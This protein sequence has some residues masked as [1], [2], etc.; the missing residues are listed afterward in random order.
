MAM[1]GMAYWFLGRRITGF[2]L[3]VA[4]LCG[5]FA[6]L[7]GGLPGHWKLLFGLWG[8]V[9]LWCG[10]EV[11]WLLQKQE[12]RLPLSLKRAVLAFAGLW[13]GPLCLGCWVFNRFWGSSYIVQSDEMFPQ[14]IQGDRIRY[15]RV[16]C[17]QLQPGSAVVI[18]WPGQGLFTTRV[19]AVG[20][21]RVH[22]LGPSILVNGQKL[23]Q[24]A[25]QVTPGPFLKAAYPQLEARRFAVEQNQHREYLVAYDEQLVENKEIFQVVLH[26]N[27]L[28]VMGDDRSASVLKGRFG[29]ISCAQVRGRPLFVQDS[30]D[31][32]GHLREE[33]AGL[34]IW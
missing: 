10:C 32:Q 21:A 5:A 15:E 17:E 19:V 24:Q 7:T 20:P 25:V 4:E 28:Y 13:L 33:R 26:R 16:S 30:H 23:A 29:Q 22:A 3:W 34:S 1:P 27:E 2:C 9:R 31:A 18:D 11:L 12:Q 8:M 6:F 14:Q